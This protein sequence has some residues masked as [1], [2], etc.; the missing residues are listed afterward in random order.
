MFPH[1]RSLVQRLNS[2]PFAL[3]GVNADDNRQ[4]AQS[5]KRSQQLTWRSFFDG[6]G[7]GNDIV[8]QYQAPGLPT[9]FLLDH[10]GIIRH[11]FIGVPR[12]EVLDRAI[13]ELVSNVN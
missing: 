3:I 1:E 13:D 10:N 4:Q 9:I 2:E 8:Q 12:D 6:P 11:R 5:V 7:F